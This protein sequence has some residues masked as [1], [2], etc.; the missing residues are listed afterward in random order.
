MRIG[1]FLSALLWLAPLQAQ[2]DLQALQ[3]RL[4]LAPVMMVV[5][6]TRPLPACRCIRPRRQVDQCLRRPLHG[7]RC[8]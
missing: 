4:A 6:H 3:Q 7:T 5:E 8:K 1:L 2:D